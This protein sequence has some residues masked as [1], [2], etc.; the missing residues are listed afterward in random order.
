MEER[1]KNIVEALLFV[2][3][4]AVEIQDIMKATELNIIEA[5][6]LMENLICELNETKRGINILKLEDSYQMCANSE[7]FT[8]IEEVYK[9]NKRSKL[10][11]SQVEVLAIIAYKQPITKGEINDIRGINSDYLINKLLEY[12]LIEEKGRKDTVGKP[13]LLGTTMEFL[14]FYGISSVSQ[15]PI[16][17][18]EEITKEAEEEA[19]QISFV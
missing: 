17:P 8:N 3:G 1:K 9:N 12:T 18:I 5:N 14:K 15:L 16:L 11:E 2:S 7:Y 10:T 13:I 4:E 6:Q 19:H